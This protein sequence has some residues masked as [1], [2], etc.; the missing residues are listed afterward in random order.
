MWYRA[1]FHTVKIM[2]WNCKNVK[3]TRCRDFTMLLLV[4]IHITLYTYAH[5]TYKMMIRLHTYLSLYMRV[6]KLVTYLLIDWCT[7]GRLSYHLRR[8]FFTAL[9]WFRSVYKISSC[10]WFCI[11]FWIKWGL[12]KTFDTKIIGW[13]HF[14]NYFKD[15]T[16]TV[17]PI[18]NFKI[19]CS[20]LQVHRNSL[21]A[22][23]PRYRLGQLRLTG[24]ISVV[25]PVRTGTGHS[26]IVAT[27]WTRLNRTVLQ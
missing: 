27:E 19:I 1:R 7:K 16:S 3:L 13:T 12:W 18:E 11:H 20:L 22:P 24:H 6:V 10:C 5:S 2:T 15:L 21:R 9:I 25:L 4:R 26:Y 8:M 14:S 23:M 17:Q